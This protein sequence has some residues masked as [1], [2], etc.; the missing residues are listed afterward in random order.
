MTKLNKSTAKELIIDTETTGLD[1][2]R[3]RIVELAIVEF[4]L[5]GPIRKLY[6]SYFNPEPIKVSK[7][8]LRIHGITN[9]LLSTKPKFESEA[10]KITQIIN[11]NKLLAHNA[12]F[13]KRMLTHELRLARLDI[14]NVCWFDTLKLANSLNPS[15]SNSLRA[16]CKKYK[17]KEIN[18]KHDAL[19]DCKMLALVYRALLNSQLQTACAGSWFNNSA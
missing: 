4:K 17:I 7:E 19:S 12:E 10:N 11:N 3:D 14:P 6:H 1:H 16:L 9:E 8:A 13:D 15:K 5:R 18:S 2:N